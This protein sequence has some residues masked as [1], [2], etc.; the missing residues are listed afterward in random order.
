MF[1][2]IITDIG[3]VIS[4][5]SG[6]SGCRLWV[7]TGF[8]M[9]TVDTGASVAC[10]GCCLTVTDKYNQ[11]FAV[12]V[13]NETLS[14]T[15]IGQWREG[16]K[17]NLEKSL[18][19]GDELGGHLVSGHIDG[20]AELMDLTEDGISRRMSFSVPHELSHYIAVKGSVA[21]DG[22]SL[23]V[24]DVEG[25]LFGVN[26]IPYTLEHTTLGIIGE[27]DKVNIEVDMLARYA[28]RILGKEGGGNG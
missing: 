13:S 17:I 8:D 14:K 28:A 1:T 26:I 16:T 12:D 22:V 2:G 25:N 21:L 15:L 23:T 19:L 5:E 27:G 10:S 18:R 11:Q 7:K 9:D 24:N 4:I 20:S 6:S 3:E